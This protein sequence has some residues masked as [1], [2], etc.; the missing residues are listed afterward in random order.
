MNAK[1]LAEYAEYLERKP[2]LYNEA[3]R[4]IPDLFISRVFRIV[5]CRMHIELQ[6]F[7]DE[8]DDCG[9]FLPRNHGKTTQL[10]IGRLAWEIG[11]NFDLRFQ[12]V[13]AILADAKK[14][15]GA[16][17]DVIESDVYRQVFPHVVPDRAGD[18]GASSFT[19]KRKRVGMRDSTMTAQPIFGKAGQ[20]SDFLVFDDIENFDNSIRQE[21][22]R[23]Q[24]KDAYRETW[25]P[26]LEPG[27]R[28]L[29][30]GTPWHIDGQTMDWIRA[31]QKGELPMFYRACEELV[32]PWPEKFPPEELRK[33]RR[34]M[35]EIAFARAF[36]LQPLSGDEVVFSGIDLM[37]ASCPLPERS[38]L[39]SPARWAAID[40]AFSEEEQIKRGKDEPDYSVMGVADITTDG[41]VY[42]VRNIRQRT[43]YPKFRAM[44]ISEAVRSGVKR[45]IIESNG[46]QKGLRQDLAGELAKHGISMMVGNR[47]NDKYARASAVQAVVE[48]GRFHLRAG[49]GGELL[50][51]MQ[52]MYREMS[53]FP[54]G[55]KDDTVDVA[56]DLMGQAR[57]AA[58]GG[59]SGDS[60]LDQTK[61]SDIMRMHAMATDGRG[62]S[63][64]E[65]YRRLNEEWWNNE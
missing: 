57:I 54:V 38:K 35:G 64:P 56:V 7:I 34:E 25:I 60:G 31:G 58:S 12:V 8:N 61:V 53:M 42:M 30:I 45:A 15:V 33:R 37:N 6:R 18:W 55:G 39:R 13:Q 16:V 26:T 2:E 49:P 43:T 14:T 28:Q 59:V 29:K 19:V 4:R 20:R 17:K 40:L 11:H 24:V 36:Y 9:V 44:V 63:T 62:N 48:Q 1:K 50:E 5:P 23:A 27:G 32:S 51:D 21:G 46:P 47:R 65:D 41:H 10:T 3:C 22:L 52:A